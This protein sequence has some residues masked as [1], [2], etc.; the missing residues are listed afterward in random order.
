MS[1][2]ERNRQAMPNVAAMID[3]WREHF[4]TLK[5]IWAKDLVTGVEVG[6]PSWRANEQNGIF[7]GFMGFNRRRA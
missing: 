6:K 7:R 4:P 1:A 3:E 5:V 2:K